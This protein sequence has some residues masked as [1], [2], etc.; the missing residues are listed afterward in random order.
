MADYVEDYEKTLL[1]LPTSDISVVPV[2]VHPLF[3]ATS[4]LKCRGPALSFQVGG[5]APTCNGP[6]S[7][8][9]GKEAG[10][11]DILPS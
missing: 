8:V 7:L 3:T 11:R 2:G 1:R 6:Y 4:K 10:P 9:L 5:V